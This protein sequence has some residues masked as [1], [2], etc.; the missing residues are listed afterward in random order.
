MLK[1]RIIPQTNMNNIKR[2]FSVQIPNNL[3]LADNNIFKQPLL[4]SSL[5]NHNFDFP[6]INVPKTISVLN[7]YKNSNNEI[8]ETPLEKRIFE[9]AIRK[10]IVHDVIRYI[11]HMR[12][13]PKKTKRIG[14]ISGST[15]KPRPQK[16]GGQSQV[17]NK[18]NSAWRKGQKA[19]GPVLRDYSIS[20]NRKVRALGMMMSL[21]AK[22]REGNLII[23]D[24]LKLK[25]FKTKE[26]MDILKSHNMSES[27]ILFVDEEFDDNFAKAVRNISSAAALIRDHTNVYEIIKREKLVISL[28]TF[29]LLQRALISMYCYSGK[30]KAIND[31]NE[32]LE[33]SRNAIIEMKL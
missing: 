23:F 11:T 12:R 10:D 20:I 24:N 9:V 6:I 5:F 3:I 17:G 25:S 33:K 15:K 22:F 26:L 13:Q 8:K 28:E 1:Y 19:H 2:L 30:R 14:E 29:Q 21:S 31:A 27:T 7:L 18:R 16:G 32:L 4:S